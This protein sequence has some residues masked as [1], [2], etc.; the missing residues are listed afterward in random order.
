MIQLNLKKSSECKVRY[1]KLHI[2]VIGLLGDRF[3]RYK[4]IDGRDD[5]ITLA[6]S[7]YGTKEIYNN[8]RVDE[9]L[10][11]CEKYLIKPRD[12]RAILVILFI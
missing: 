2:L 7:K 12:L 9:F 4:Y 11:F 10:K 6:Y 8:L 5:H 3:Y 1:E